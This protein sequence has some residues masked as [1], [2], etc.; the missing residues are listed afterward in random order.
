MGSPRGFENKIVPPLGIR[1]L[2]IDSGAVK[3]QS[4][5]TILKTIWKLFFGVFKAI[6]II[7]Q[8]KAAAVIGVGGYVSVPV[9]FAAFLTRTPL[10]L[11]E[12]NVSVGIANRVLGRLARKVFLGF[13]EGEQ[14]FPRGRTLVTGNPIRKDF[15]DPKF[16]TVPAACTGILVFGG[17]QGAKAINDAFIQLLPELSVK[18]PA[19]SILHQTGEKDLARVKESYAKFFS[20]RYEVLPFITD[21][22][23]AYASASLVVSRSGALTVSE[24]I[25]VGR[26]ALLVP[27][28]RKGQNDQTANAY[29]LQKHGVGRVVEQGR[30]FEQRFRE[31]FLEVFT[32]TT[33]SEMASHFSTLR[34]GNA[35]A[36]IGLHIEKELSQ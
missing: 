7:H 32:P 35:L 6:R 20:G 34:G 26:P 33:L 19:L 3:N 12:Q 18:Y 22:A 14:F 24:L 30:D 23:S 2:T 25:Q 15:F 4:P 11:Q 13:E 8:E 31:T 5:L 16:E 36:S 27:F 9:G 10:Y 29:L 28:P 1:F 17:S 21:M